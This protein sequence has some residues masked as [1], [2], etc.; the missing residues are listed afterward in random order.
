[1]RAFAISTVSLLTT[2]AWLEGSAFAQDQPPAPAPTPAAPPEKPARDPKREPESDKAKNPPPPAD[3][4]R[5]YETP[6]GTEPE[7]V[8]LFV[9]RVVLGVPRYVLRFLFFP[10]DAGLQALDEHAV[11][12]S[13]EDFLYNDERT[14]GVTPRIA[15][16]TFFGGSIGAT[17]FHDDLAGH[18]EHL[19]LS[20]VFGGRYEQAY[21]LVFR[22]DRYGGSRLWLESMSRFEV[23]P[24]LLFQGIGQPPER[25]GGS[26][27]DPREA[28][29]ETRYR[30]ERLLGLMRVGYTVGEPGALTKIGMT[31]IYNRREFEPKARGTGPST[32]TVYDTSE[33]VGYDTGVNLAETDLNLIVDTRDV[34]GWTSSGAYVELFGGVV[35]KFNDYGFFHHGVEA[36]GYFNLYKKTRVLVLRGVVEGVEGKTEEIPFSE[37]PRLGGPNRLRGYP[38][39]RFRDEKAALG[40]VEYHYPIHQ[41]VAGS[42][43]VDVGRVAESYDEIAKSDGWNTGFGA[44]FIFRSKNNVIFTFDVAY[45]DGVQFH[46]TTDPLRAF[47]DRD[48]EL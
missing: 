11:I 22:A 26:S 9:P 47:G 28:A 48:T 21:N 42:L 29:V 44:G 19:S 38:L 35:P 20:A 14:A 12:E 32:E 40:T 18:G 5:G 46:L 31:G 41:Y 4:A 25:T 37:L 8:A 30:Q 17:A 6:P 2:F 15:L 3:D 24:G 36:T 10:I 23:E 39:D 45:G 27:L 1:M 16:D 33:L 43:Y 13:V 7:D 34:Q